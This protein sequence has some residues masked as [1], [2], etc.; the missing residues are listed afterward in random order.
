MADSKAALCGKVRPAEWSS[1]TIACG[2][3]ALEKFKKS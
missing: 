1:L 3:I 2:K